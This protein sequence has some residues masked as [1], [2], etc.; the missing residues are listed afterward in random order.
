MPS[1]FSLPAA[2]SRTPA[3]SPL[4]GA[5]VAAAVED[6]EAAGPLDDQAELRQAFHAAPTRA[7][8]VRT[9]A[10]LLGQRLG[11]SRELTRW[12]H[13]LGWVAASLALL[14]ALA[15][16]GAAGGVLAP[17]RSINAV[18]AFVSLLGL[19]AFTLLAWLLG[20]AWSLAGHRAGAGG[21]SLGRLALGLAARLPLDRGPHALTLLS[22]FTGLMR[23]N[24]LWPWLTGMLS[25]GIWTLAFGIT[26]AALLFT[27]SFHDYRL[28][29]ETTI[30]SAG[31]FQRFVHA[32]G[33]LPA[34][35]GFPVPDAAA[36]QQVGNAGAAASLSAGGQREWA[37]W[38]IG[39]V[40]V[41]GLLPRALLAAFSLWRWR[42]GVGRMEQVDMTDPGVRR[43]VARLDALEPPPQVI[44]PGR[45]PAAAPAPAATLPAGAPSVPG[46][47]AV[48][49][50][51][52]P[53]D[54]PWPPAGLPAAGAPLRV[55]GGAAERA[56]ALQELRAQR[57][58]ALL[59]VCHAPSSP[60][61]GTARFVRE[62]SALADRTAIWLT[63]GDNP[64]PE[65]AVRRWR[66]WGTLEKFMAVTLVES[67][68]AASEWIASGHA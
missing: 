68:Q 1:A 61:R 37:W 13:A 24:R 62:A 2:P 17:D 23:R 26:L 8:Q 9:R 10:W 52:L 16:L 19:H 5:V 32:T 20:L 29:W 31:F 53:P 39:C 43:I 7:A 48:I 42:A 30:L 40:A 58:A 56:Q 28:S 49:G 51:E 34:A 45:H 27:L 65:A 18:A 50:F 21:W 47:P 22:A 33:A 36:V 60:D 11:L 14:V 41:Y 4:A 67:A 66:E 15:G 44:D 63:A 35:L 46:A 64:L 3:P 25:H 38:L 59:L 54:G 12:R 55:A 57:P 6:I